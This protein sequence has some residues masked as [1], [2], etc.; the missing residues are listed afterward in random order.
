MHGKPAR[1]DDSAAEA[2]VAPLPAVE[3]AGRFAG[4]TDCPYHTHAGHELVL[5]TEGACRIRVGRQ[6]LDGRPGTLFVLAAGVPQY[7]ETFGFTRTS[8]VI[9]QAARHACDPAS[10]TLTPG[11]AMVERWLEDLCDLFQSPRPVPPTLAGALLLAILERVRQ[12]ER[13]A[14]IDLHP[15]VARALSLLES[16]FDRPLS[17]AALSAHACVSASHLT[18]L[19]RAEFGCG[20]MAYLQR[21]RLGQAQKLLRDP[22]RSV[23]E[24]AR[25]CG[26][27]DPNYFARLF[28]RRV[29]VAPGVWRNTA[30]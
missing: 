15:G 19:F 5:V 16:G 30:R 22:Y 11:D 20:P 3:Y 6:R 8:Y 13:Q 29:G 21:L 2:P 24:I 23:A 28:R 4:T 27:D 9:F 26:Y 12:I 18:A 10:R 1:S 17:M 7:Q 25:A 14:S